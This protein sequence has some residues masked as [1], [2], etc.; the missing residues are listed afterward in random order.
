[1]PFDWHDYLDLARW[2]EA[3][4]PP[5]TSD[6]AAK[7]TAISRAYYAAFCYARNYA[8]HYL[9]FV[10]RDDETDHGRLRAHLRQRRRH[11]TADKL[12]SLR[13]ARN[14]CDYDDNVTED[15]AAM[16]GTALREAD[17]VFQSLPPPA[18]P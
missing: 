13:D 3:N 12:D 8:R 16:L 1:M 7:R 11:G 4:T 14:Q 17:Y 2:L 18:T 9:G 15:L 10:P 6:E 5:G